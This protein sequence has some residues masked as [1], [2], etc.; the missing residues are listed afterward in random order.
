MAAQPANLSAEEIAWRA[1]EDAQDGELFRLA[2]YTGLR[3]GEL[4]ALRWEDVDFD[5][6]RMV[7][8]RAVSAGVEG[9]TKSWQARF[10]PLADP[11]AEALERLRARG[12]YTSREDY[13]FCSRLGRRL[14]PSAVRRRFKAARDAAGLRPL[15]FHAL[16]HAAGS[17]IARH[18]DAR[19]VQEFLGHSRI[20]TT[21]R[22]MHAKARP[23]DLE[24]VNLRVC[25]QTVQRAGEHRG[26]SLIARTLIAIADSIRGWW[27]CM[28]VIGRVRQSTAE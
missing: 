15:R 11:A 4:I 21:E 9:P 23:E 27:Q 7:V 12:D 18:A 13:V 14:D 26:R 2:A 17:L 5:T 25:S 6:R 16:R 1:R 3:L 28:A 8:H 10:L 24:R 19:F 20:T 22:Y